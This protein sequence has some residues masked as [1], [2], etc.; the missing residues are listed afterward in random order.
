MISQ[1][2]TIAR[3]AFVESLRQPAMLFLVLGSGVLQVLIPWMT[4]F[5]MGQEESGELE[6]DNKLQFDIGLSSVFV[7]ATILAAFIATTTLSREIENKTALTVVSKPVNRP[8]VIVGKYF[9][10]SLALLI[11]LGS[12]IIFL[13]VS[14]RHGVMSNASDQVDQPAILFP[15]A[16]VFLALISAGWLNFF[17]GWNFPQTAVSLLFPLLVVAFFLVMGFDKKWTSQSLLHD[18]KPQVT[19]AAGALTLAVM[20]LTSIAVAASTRLSQIMT[21]FLCL[22]V[23]VA[24]LLTNHLLGRY[25]FHNAPIGIVAAAASTDLTRKAFDQSGDT[26]TIDLIRPANETLKPGTPFYFGINA[27][28]FDLVWPA[29]QEFSGDPTKSEDIL[30]PNAPAAVIITSANGKSLTIRNIGA[31][32]VPLSRPPQPRDYAFIRPTR[33]NLAA[34]VP[35]SVLPN[36]HYFWLLDAVSQNQ[37][38]PVGYL[39]TAALYACLQI[40]AF[41]SL[42]VVLFQKRDVG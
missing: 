17:Y 39:G 38:V 8:T 29:Y 9:G 3:N 16:A 18:F 23:F 6:G 22:G 10:V 31:D 36:M 41:L 30:G 40:G 19:V 28:G 15:L 5:A 11:A 12:M 2:L 1:S 25:A 27:N 7:C 34:I 13:L 42:A 35:W 26:Y 24:S 20:V 14:V 37:P 33:H 21:V 32:G 4:G